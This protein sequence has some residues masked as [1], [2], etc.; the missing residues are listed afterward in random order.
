MIRLCRWNSCCFRSVHN[1][2]LRPTHFLP[3]LCLLNHF[4]PTFS[5]PTKCLYQSYIIWD[6]NF[7][8]KIHGE[9]STL[10]WT[11]SDEWSDCV[12]L[13]LPC[14]DYF[15]KSQILFNNTQILLPTLKQN[16]SNCVNGSQWCGI[17]YSTTM[18]YLNRGHILLLVIILFHNK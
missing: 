12:S 14:I 17:W 8:M 15:H 4:S 10:S 5:K 3:K 2:C 6:Y 16:W 18:W 13:A 7:A 11:L 1:K 9:L